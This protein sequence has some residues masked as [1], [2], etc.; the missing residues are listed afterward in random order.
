[1]SKTLNDFLKKA[2]DILLPIEEPAETKNPES[3]VNNLY[4]CS[5]CGKSNNEVN[6]LIASQGV[7]ICDA[8]IESFNNEIAQEKKID[9][10]KTCSFCGKSDREVKRLIEGKDACICDACV[11]I[12]AEMLKTEVSDRKDTV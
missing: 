5:F 11:K 4:K 12:C 8:C 1:M 2:T 3:A 10:G 7:N 6:R 9:S